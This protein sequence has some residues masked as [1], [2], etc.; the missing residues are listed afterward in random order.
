MHR[1]KFF[2]LAPF[3]VL[4]FVL[5]APVKAEAQT[6]ASRFAFRAG[7]SMYIVAYRYVLPSLV[8]DSVEV[9]QTQQDRFVNALDVEKKVRDEIE[10]WRYF[11]VA[12]KP[13]DAD[14]IFLVNL[15]GSA[16]EGIAVPSDA[17]RQHF[18]EKYDL[19][20]LRDAA[21]GRYIAGP[22]KLPTLSRLSERLVKHFRAGVAPSNAKAK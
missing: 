14:F 1:N 12:D 20:A 22:L 19:D 8:L 18:K 16:M 9:S 15:D 17:Y 21:H 6:D 4:V 2:R 5:L 7:Q 13:S 11:R 3:F 10:K